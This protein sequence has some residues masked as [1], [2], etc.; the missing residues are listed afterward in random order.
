MFWKVPGGAAPARPPSSHALLSLGASRAQCCASLAPPQLAAWAFPSPHQTSPPPPTWPPQA[1]LLQVGKPCEPCRR[2]VGVPSGCYCSR[3]GQERQPG[4]EE[5][6]ALGVQVLVQSSA[7]VSPV[8]SAPGIPTL[9][10]PAT[11][12]SS[13]SCPVS[14]A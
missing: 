2:E 9:V 8:V 4:L 1:L 11:L 6:Q 14:G 3:S 10:G 5:H 12:P 7:S 13:T